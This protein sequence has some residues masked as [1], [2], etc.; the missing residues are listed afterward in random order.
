MLWKY[1][2]SVADEYDIKV[3]NVKRLVPNLGNKNKYVLSYRNIQLYLSFGMK[4]KKYI[5]C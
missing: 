5:K 2:K 1:C 3:G 4:L